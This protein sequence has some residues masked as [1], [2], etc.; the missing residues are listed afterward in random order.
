MGA[1]LRAGDVTTA[2]GSITSYARY[3]ELRADGRAD[4]AGYVLKEIEDYNHYD[5]RSTQELRNW[6]TGARLG[7]R[8]HTDWRPTRSGRRHRRRP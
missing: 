4:E 6:L 8:R 7:I 2:T 5:C 1:Q 3:C